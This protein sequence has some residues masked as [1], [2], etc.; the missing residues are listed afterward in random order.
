M[1]V[2]EDLSSPPLQKGAG[3]AADS[4]S[5]A[6]LAVLGVVLAGIAVVFGVVAMGLSSRGGGSSG[7]AV[8]T[9]PKANV[10]SK[11]TLTDFTISASPNTW[12]AGPALL[13]L[14]NKGPSP[15]SLTIDG[16]AKSSVIAVGQKTL[17]SL[18]NVEAGT[19]T[20][21]C[22]I[23]GHREAG[24]SGIFTVTGT[25]P[26]SAASDVAGATPASADTTLSVQAASDKVDTAHK[27]VVAQFLSGPPAKTAGLGGQ[28]L[29][30]T[31]ENGVKVFNLTAEVV[32]WEVAPGKTYEAWTYNGVVPGPQIRMKQGETVKVR[33]KNN[34]PQSTSIHWHGL[35]I[36]DNKQADRRR[37]AARV[38]AGRVR[39]ARPIVEAAAV[40]ARPSGERTRPVA[41]GAAHAA[42]CAAG[43]G[44]DDG[45]RRPGTR[46]TARAVTRHGPW[47]AR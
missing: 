26:A 39:V 43:R 46:W 37:S 45:W 21:Y 7:T 29:A 9:A 40:L 16:M 28:L 41:I 18:G 32:Q 13:E 5:S 8:A 2:V 44:G 36:A 42:R 15:H 1:T 24:M 34:L 10:V 4:P 25:A 6:G 22:S 31:I 38:R 23:A 11:V 47:S 12:T 20:W 3:A 35:E 14:T 30:P 33:L 17:L 27:E 19:Y